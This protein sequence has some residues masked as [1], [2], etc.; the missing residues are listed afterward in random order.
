MIGDPECRGMIAVMETA[1]KNA[2]VAVRDV[3]YINAHGTGTQ[4]NDH[5]ETKA[6]TRV[7]GH[8]T[9]NKVAVSSTK[10]MIGH[11]LGAAGAIESVATILALGEQAAPPTINLA[12]PE[13]DL[14]Y[15]PNEASVMGIRIA[16]SNSFAFGGN[17]TSL[18]FG[19]VEN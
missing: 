10:S 2:G 18:V 12:D 14:H 1:L 17:N 9:S 3:N 15:V 7:F 16:M 19:R 13:F 11:C 6:I 8:E 4:K 5:L